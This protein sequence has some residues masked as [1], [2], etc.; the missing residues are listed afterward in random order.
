MDECAPNSMAEVRRKII[1]YDRRRELMDFAFHL[2][3][4][5]MEKTKNH[6]RCLLRSMV[7]N[8]LETS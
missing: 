1:P 8:L 6:E 4:Q 2:A 7:E 5:V 3:E